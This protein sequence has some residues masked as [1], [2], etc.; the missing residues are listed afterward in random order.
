MTYLELPV[1]HAQYI[2]FW[3]KCVK[4]A[5]IRDVIEVKANVGL[6][7]LAECEDEHADYLEQIAAQTW[8]DTYGK[9]LGMAAYRAKIDEH[10]NPAPK[11]E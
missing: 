10:G 9:P 6:V 8:I 2:D 11:G 3:R 7:Y 4:V 5:E 1:A